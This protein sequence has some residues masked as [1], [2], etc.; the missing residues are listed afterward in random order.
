MKNLLKKLS[1]FI[2]L[3]IV[4]S[5]FFICSVYAGGIQPS[6]PETGYVM[7]DNV[8][9]GKG[10]AWNDCSE[11]QQNNRRKY[12]ITQIGTLVL[13]GAADIGDFIF[14]KN[15][16]S[17][18]AFL[19]T[20]ETYT[21]NKGKIIN[22]GI[23][24][25]ELLCNWAGIDID[26]VIQDD[27][28]DPNNIKLPNNEIV[29]SADFLNAIQE[30]INELNSSS[31]KIVVR[32][33]TPSSRT[34]WVDPSLDNNVYSYN[35]PGVLKN[36]FE[37]M[38]K[39]HGIIWITYNGYDGT[40]YC[41][42]LEGD[43][44]DYV[45]YLYSTQPAR[46]GVQGTFARVVP[47][48]KDGDPVVW[49][50]QSIPLPGSEKDPQLNRFLELTSNAPIRHVAENGSFTTF[51]CAYDCEPVKMIESIRHF[52]G[53]ITSSGRFTIYSDL[54]AALA[55]ALY[56][57]GTIPEIIQKSDR[58]VV[59]DN[60]VTYKIDNSQHN[61]YNYEYFKDQI[62]DTTGMSDD[63]VQDKI[64]EIFNSLESAIESG[65]NIDERGF[66]SLGKLISNDLIELLNRILYEIRVIGD[67][68]KNI[69]T[70]DSGG[71]LLNTLANLATGITSVVDLLKDFF[72]E[73]VGSAVGEV[74]EIAA[75][76]ADVPFL[77][78]IMGQL[79]TINAQLGILVGDEILEDVGEVVGDGL[80]IGSQVG[81]LLTK[82]FPFS[83]PWD[84][85][86]IINSL[87]SAPATPIFEIPLVIPS[88][89]ID[90]T[91]VID[92]SDFQLLSD[93]AKWFF[94]I[95]YILAITKL[96]LKILEVDIVHS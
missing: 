3:Y 61:T 65:S 18:N 59:H 66:D 26:S 37:D 10:L 35:M 62:G 16:G 74:G 57:K 90:T 70:G 55:G 49:Y 15:S 78:G 94:D 21:I 30:C 63:Q 68:V 28:Y 40:G 17:I 84:I 50:E 71:G 60:S 64:D 19:D 69:K 39:E 27:N 88:W 5:N 53:A 20:L 72:V 32:T 93:V 91:F 23:T 6:I 29:Y 1:V 14:G 79:S 4:V 51:L 95:L 13:E 43:I 54:G 45:F 73:D 7:T 42:Y 9:Y 33:H 75:E 48:R 58:N 12:A 31:D 2:C 82:K 11:E 22:E 77:T 67:A 44:S 89:G 47:I 46:A 38:I 80:D 85:Q 83:I 52:E 56:N 86:L 81:E 76:V 92:L 87:A 36:Y 8:D 25:E 24:G 96:S 41:N 34:S